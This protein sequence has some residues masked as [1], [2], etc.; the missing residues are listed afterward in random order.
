MTKA[1]MNRG[2]EK[3]LRKLFKRDLMQIADFCQREGVQVLD[4]NPDPGME[5]YYITPAVEKMGKADFETGGATDVDHLEAALRDLWSE[6]RCL[7]FAVLAE[8]VAKLARSVRATEEQSS[9]LS[10]FVY[11]MY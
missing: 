9:E 7:V 11:V 8:R 2:V 1:T 10:Q 5:S 6:E 4:P 3:Q